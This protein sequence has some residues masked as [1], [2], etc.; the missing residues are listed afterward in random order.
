M[1]QAATTSETDAPHPLV[2]RHRDT[3][4][5]A[6][7]ATRERRFWSHYPESPSPR[8]YGEGAAEEGRAAFDR[9]LHA[10][11]PLEQPGTDG[12]VAGER[13][14][15]GIELGVRYPHADIDALLPAMEAGVPA[16]RT[17]G[18]QLRA[19]VCVEI[20]DRLNKRCFELAYAIMHTTGQAFV[21]AF[22]AGGAHAQDRALEAIAYAYAEMTRHVS[23]AYWEKPQGKHDPLRMEKTFTVVPRGVALVVGCNTFPTWNG[24]PGLFASLATGNPVAVKPHP[25]AVLPLAIT[26]AVAREVL[27]EAGFDANLVCLAAERPEEKLASVLATRP[28]V[29]VIDF[30]GSTAYGEW[31]EEHARQAVVY[32]EKAGVN[33]IV[34]DSTDDL[35]GM[36][37][38]IAFSL[39]LYSGQMCTTP[40]NILIPRE[41]VETDQGHKSFDEVVQA[42]ATGVDKLL[43]D[44]VRAV[45]VLGA[46]VN[47]SVL[48]RLEEAP[49][50]G[51]VV[52]ESAALTHPEFADAVV[53]TP[54]IVRLDAAAEDA[55]AQEHFGPI[56]FVIATD[57]T[58]HSLDV[59]GRTVRAQG[60]LTASVYSTSEDVLRAAED[61]AVDAGVALSCNLTGGV[62]VNQSAAFSD[63]HGTGA[64]PAANAALTDGAFVAGRFRIVQSRRPAPDAA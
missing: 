18:P 10:R 44:P 6:V 59:V 2:D 11:F 15:Y 14:P 19:A 48:Q 20:L 50:Y 1:T 28:E 27:E 64:N 54:V 38:N 62:F 3:L 29:R 4:D 31:L 26:V 35:K 52:R 43:G 5:Q 42:I 32:T 49:S 55:Y 22:Q 33:S 25:R 13:S 61:V 7:T 39:S 24:Y 37:R 40:Q 47:E 46:V 36:T 57:G 58:E 56:T 63:F 34:I 51:D 53:R 8:V 30:T 21:M 45:E 12:E 41:G 60:A 9:Y 17:A 16:W 23:S